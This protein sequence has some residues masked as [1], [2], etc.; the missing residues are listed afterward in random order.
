[1]WGRGCEEKQKEEEEGKEGKT[2]KGEMCGKL[3]EREKAR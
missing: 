1:M 3:D 2:E